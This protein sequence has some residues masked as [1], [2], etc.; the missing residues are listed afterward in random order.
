MMVM[1]FGKG[2]REF[3]L[4]II[5]CGAVLILASC[6]VVHGEMKI[7]SRSLLGNKLLAASLITLLF[8]AS[9]VVGSIVHLS[10]R[11]NG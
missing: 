1:P 8:G 4:A 6:Y 10:S 2:E 9:L 3:P 7:K 11:S 5:G